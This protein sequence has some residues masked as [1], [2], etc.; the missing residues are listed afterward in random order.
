M[1][2]TENPTHYLI[3]AQW[4]LVYVCAHNLFELGEVLDACPM[5]VGKNMH[6]TGSRGLVGGTW[7]VGTHPP[8]NVQDV[9]GSSRESVQ[10]T[11]VQ[12]VV[13]RHLGMALK[14]LKKNSVAAGQAKNYGMGFVRNMNKQNCV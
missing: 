5:A 2:F 10:N 4:P 8:K 14:S 11:R 13:R 3:L 6:E 9:D 7:V 1:D 12:Q